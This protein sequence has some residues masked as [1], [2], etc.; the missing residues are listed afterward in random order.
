MKVQQLQISASLFSCTFQNPPVRR[1]SRGFRRHCL[2]HACA[3]GTREEN[4]LVRLA[5][6]SLTNVLDFARFGRSRE[7]ELQRRFRKVEPGDIDGIMRCIREDY[8]QH[9]YFVTGDIWEGV[10]S[11]NCYFGDPTVS[12][13]GLQKWRQNLQLLV[14]FLEDPEIELFSLKRLDSS[15]GQGAVKLKAEWRLSTYLR[16]PWR[17]FIDVLGS[18]EYTLDDASQQVVRHI[19]SWNISGTEAIL[20]ILRPSSGQERMPS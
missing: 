8:T 3:S 2:T 9:A 5:V 18:T 14:P 11:E 17:P 10:Y 20:Q 1:G 4:A 12:F 19:E 6:A 15:N 13:T 16:L 7:P